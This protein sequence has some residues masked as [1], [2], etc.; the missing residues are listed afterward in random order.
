MFVLFKDIRPLIC[1]YYQMDGG[2]HLYLCAS[3]E[4]DAMC[5]IVLSG[6]FSGSHIPS[7]V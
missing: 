4:L 6:M 1:K 5:A 7:E 2:T 3:I